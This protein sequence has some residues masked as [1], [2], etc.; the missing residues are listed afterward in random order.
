MRNKIFLNISQPNLA[1][2][3]FITFSDLIIEMF[4]KKAL[5]IMLPEIIHCIFK[6][7]HPLHESLQNAHKSCN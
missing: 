2:E 6:F 7:I 4:L 3:D 1:I 5:S